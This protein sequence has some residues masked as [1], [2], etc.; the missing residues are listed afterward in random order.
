MRELS[1][2][3]FKTLTKKPKNDS[4][5]MAEQA[6]ASMREAV[7]HNEAVMGEVAKMLMIKPIR[8]DITRDKKGDI[9]SITPIYDKLR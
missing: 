7:N 5:R 9:V 2:A 8:F 4:T 1:T 6:I 3:Q